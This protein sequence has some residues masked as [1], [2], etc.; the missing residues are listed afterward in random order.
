MEGTEGIEHR[1]KRLAAL[2]PVRPRTLTAPPPARSLPRARRRSPAR[3]ALTAAL[4]LALALPA[5]Q[6]PTPAF[7]L[8]EPD[9]APS[10]DDAAL[11]ASA[12]GPAP[13][14]FAAQ[15]RPY[16]AAPLPIEAAPGAV[17]LATI[18]PPRGPTVLRSLGTGVASY[19]GKR[20]HGRRT[21]NGERF[22]M[23]AMTAAHK[24]LPF[25]THV[26]VTN[27]RNGKSVT[28]RIND[29]GP[30]IRGRTIDLSRAAARE[31]GLI[32]SGHARVTM[33]VVEP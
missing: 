20:F 4:G 12:S 21:A 25:G 24:T 33:E 17:D 28:V 18:E 8:A 16:A 30:F 6:A 31:I 26:R 22:D 1:P 23:N 10:R 9:D 11:E 19:Y 13:S 2:Q 14:A 27:R 29:R 7:A 15:F 5:A 32:Q 3:I